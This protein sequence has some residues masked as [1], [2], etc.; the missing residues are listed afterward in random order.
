MHEDHIFS[1]SPEKF[2]ESPSSNYLLE[3]QAEMLVGVEC[4]DAANC[5]FKKADG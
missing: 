5:F 1:L 4:S 3:K 2:R